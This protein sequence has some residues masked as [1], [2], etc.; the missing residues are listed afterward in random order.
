MFHTPIPVL[1]CPVIGSQPPLP[2]KGW[3]VHIYTVPHMM[4]LCTVFFSSELRG[5]IL[6]Y[7]QLIIYLPTLPKHPSKNMIL[8][9]EQAQEI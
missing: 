1:Y 8:I 5:R 2:W 9:T 7:W 4:P 3:H 6:E